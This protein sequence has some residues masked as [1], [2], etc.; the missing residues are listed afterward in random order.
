MTK[1]AEKEMGSALSPFVLIRGAG[2]MASAIAARLFRANIRRICLLD[3]ENPLCVRRHVSF[4]PALQNGAASVEGIAARQARNT[5]EMHALWQQD[6]IAVMLLADWDQTGKT[7]P[8]IVIDAILAKTNLGTTMA[9]ADLVLAL[10]PGFTAGVDCHRII[11]TN[12]GHDLGR[13]IDKGRAA[14]NTGIPGTIG[15]ETN[16]RILRAPCDGF[17]RSTAVIGGFL[18]KGETVGHV[19]D[20][21]VIVAIDGMIRGLIRTETKVTAGLK[22]GDIDPRGE[23]SFCYTVSDKARAISGS[24]LECVMRHVNRTP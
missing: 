13:V 17:F 23:Q 5:Q 6:R 1:A 3:L 21:P 9:D 19:Q 4:C 15:G 12:R 11:E 20:Q 7:R 24:V 18:H 22:L 16:R 2:E 10:G 14:P 8:D